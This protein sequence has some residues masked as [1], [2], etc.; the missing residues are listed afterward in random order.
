[1]LDIILAVEVNFRQMKNKS[2]YSKLWSMTK[3]RLMFLHRWMSQSD[4]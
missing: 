1:M 2:L 4:L 3:G